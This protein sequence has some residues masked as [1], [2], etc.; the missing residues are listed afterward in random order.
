MSE[1]RPEP[2]ASHPVLE[3][4]NLTCGYGATPILHGVNLA[5]REGEMVALLG[6]NGSG[7]S[8]LL[9]CLGGALSPLAGTVSLLGRPL[10]TRTRRETA[11]L[12]AVVQQDL[13]I[14]FTLQ[15]REVVEL[16]RAPHT[17]FLQPPHVHDRTA[18]DQALAAVDLLELAHQEYQQISGGEQQRTVLAMALAQEPRVLL[19]DEPTVHLDLAHQV[20]LLSGVRRLA[21]EQHLG[22]LAAMHDINLAAL[23]FDRL[24]VLGQ[25]CLLASGAAQEILTPDLIARAFDLEVIVGAHPILGVP[26]ISL[27]PGGD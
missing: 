5:V 18:V 7:K 3:A 8:T 23:Y 11:Q 20:G 13:H 19:L 12:L 9:R 6:R 24:L 14:P 10:A 15:V 25:G 17:H 26:Q 22:V 4:H 21:A 2:T 27:L 16:G 1:I